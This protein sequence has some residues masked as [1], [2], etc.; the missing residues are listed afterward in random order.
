MTKHVEKEHVFL[1]KRFKKEHHACPQ[2]LLEWEP[3]T[4]W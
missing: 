4:K 1:L 2:G 3:T